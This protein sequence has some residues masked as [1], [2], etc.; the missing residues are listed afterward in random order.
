MKRIFTILVCLLGSF[1]VGAQCPAGQTEITLEINA[2]SFGGEVGWELVDATTGMVIAC[3]PAG[4]YATGDVV[5]E[6][7]FCVTDGNTIIFTGYD[8]FGDDW[9]GGFVNITITEDG[10]T[11][12]CAAQDGCVVIQN[13]GENVDVEPDV[14]VINSC[15]TSNEEFTLTLTTACDATPI[16]GCTDPAAPN[17]NTCAS[18]DD[19]SCTPPQDECVGAVPYPGDVLAGTCVTNFDFTVFTDSGNPSPT[20]DFGGDAVAW[21][22]WTAP[23][24][25]AAGDPIDLTFDDGDGQAMDCDIGIEAYEL[26]CTTPASNCLGNVSGTLTGLTQGTDYVLL[27][28]D[29]GPPEAS[30]DF[31][32]S[33]ACSA[34]IVTATATCQPGDEGNFYVDVDVTNFGVGNTAYTVDVGGPQANITATGMVTYGPFP[35]GTPVDVVLTGV[36]DATCGATIMGL[37]KD[38]MCD[39]LSVEAVDDGTVCPGDPFT[40]DATLNDVIIGDF[41]D[42]TVTPGTAGSCTAVADNPAD[43]VDLA[44]GDD[45]GSGAIPLG[46]NFDFFGVTYSSVCVGSNGYVT[47]TCVDEIDLS[48]DPIPNATDPNAIVALFWDDLNAADAISGIVCT[49]PA[50]IGGQTCFVADYQGVAHFGGGETVTGQIIICPDNTVTINCIDCQSDGGVDTAVQGIEDETGATGAFDP[51]FPDGVVPG[52]AT[53]SNCVTFTPNVDPDSACDFVAWVTDVN[54]I[55]GT[56]VSTTNPFDVNPTMTTTYF[57]VVDCDGVPCFDDVVVTMDD[58]ANCTVCQGIDLAAGLP[59]IPTTV[60]SGATADICLTLIDA[61]EGLVVTG[62]VDGA[63]VVLAG[64]AGAG[65]NE[66]CVTITAPINETCAPVDVVIQIDAIQC[67]DGTDFPGV[68]GGATLVE[69]LTNQGINPLNVPV[70]PT[71][72]VNTS[73]DGMCSDLVA[74]LV[75]TD[76]TVCAAAAG[77]PFTCTMDGGTLDFDFTADVT[78]FTDVPADCPLPTLTGTLTCGM[79]TQPCTATV[80]L[81][82]NPTDA[83]ST[84]GTVD[85][86]VDVTAGDAAEVSLDVDGIVVMGTTGDAQVCVAVTLNTNQTCAA[87]AQDYMVSATCAN[88][89]ELLPATAGSINVHPEGYTVVTTGDAMCGAL[90][91]ELQAADGSTCGTALSFTC[92]T[93]GETLDYDFTADADPMACTLPTLTGTLTCTGCV[94]EEE[95][96]Y[97]VNAL[98]C[99]MTGASI[100]LLDDAGMTISTMA[101][102][103]DGGS[104][105]FGIQPCGDYMIAIIG[106]PACYTERGGDVGPRVFNVDGTGSTT[107]SFSTL[108]ANIP[109]VGEWGLIILGLLMSITAVVGIR[110]RREEEIYG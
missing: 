76:G 10:S 79:C 25:T 27:I 38:C 20:C 5:T 40:L 94:C 49:Y 35:S 85:I 100:E 31:C 56:T 44:L 92:T 34:P 51:A 2:P 4:T 13:G 72:T 7:P 65:A 58:P 22:S 64:V 60:C 95:V 109:T 42:Y 99:D 96:F 106:A 12:G 86:C 15:E 55:A 62:T 21:F 1:Y 9:N 101:L 46:F 52:A 29:D 108:V 89:D 32:L 48:E 3:Q 18:I 11:N 87:T 104:G 43:C 83:C 63:P 8:S 19:G 50:T 103:L 16:S 23:I 47:F 107:E 66:L 33:I 102:G 26:D 75:A 59:D 78:V 28:Y 84:D 97:N 110:Q 61:A 77:S 45:T 93:D 53:T 57:A 69:D 36:D 39:P 6:G 70:Y 30:C 82:A 68:L 54:D 37:D 14:S 67:T 98:D 90:T 24:I 17:F 80:V 105:S 88:G 91:A 74:E 71:L 81:S 73:G 41:V